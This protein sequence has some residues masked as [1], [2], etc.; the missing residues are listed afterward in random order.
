VI[1]LPAAGAFAL[2]TVLAGISRRY[3]PATAD[4]VALQLEYDRA[5]NV[6]PP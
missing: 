3:G 6:G 1:L 2:D 5:V 4:F